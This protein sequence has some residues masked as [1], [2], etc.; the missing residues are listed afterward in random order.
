MLIFTKFRNKA[1][2]YA[3]NNAN[4]LWNVVKNKNQSFLI[5]YHIYIGKKLNA[6]R[7]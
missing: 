4:R 5:F 2:I 3:K 1:Y 6:R 7:C